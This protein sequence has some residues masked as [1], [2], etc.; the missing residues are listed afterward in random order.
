MR[1]L[2]IEDYKFTLIILSIIC[3]IFISREY[4]PKPPKQFGVKIE[5]H[6]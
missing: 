4:R 6:Y 3:L 2:D 1:K 5:K